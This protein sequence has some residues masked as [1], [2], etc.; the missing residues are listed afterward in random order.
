MANLKTDTSHLHSISIMQIA[1][2]PSEPAAQR[3]ALP[4]IDI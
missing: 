4:S 3:E 1:R 2:D